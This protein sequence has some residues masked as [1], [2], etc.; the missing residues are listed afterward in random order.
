MA[1]AFAQRHP[2]IMVY[3]LFF[4]IYAAVL[5]LILA[6]KDNQIVLWFVQAV[7]VIV[8][9]VLARHNQRFQALFVIFSNTIFW[10]TGS[11]SALWWVLTLPLC[12]SFGVDFKVNVLVL[13]L[14]TLLALCCQSIISRLAKWWGGAREI[15]FWRAYQMWALLWPLNFMAPYWAWRGKDAWSSVYRV[16]IQL[17]F[18]VIQLILHVVGIIVPIITMWIRYSDG[19]ID[20]I[21]IVSDS[22]LMGALV[23]FWMLV[24]IWDPAWALLLGKPLQV[25]SRQVLMGGMVVLLA[26]YLFISGTSTAAQQMSVLIPTF[27][28]PTWFRNNPD[29]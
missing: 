24:S 6:W 27:V 25:S 7:I 15:H 10:F 22:R 19:K 17:V 5:A 2:V 16:Y 8:F 13:L 26:V 20:V 12:L 28:T 3:F 21:E 18:I 29:P 23:S 11:L 9:C 1:L 14:G 4:F